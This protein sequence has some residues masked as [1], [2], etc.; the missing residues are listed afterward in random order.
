MQTHQ[1][2]KESLYKSAQNDYSK[3]SAELVELKTEVIRAIRGESKFAPEL[4]NGLIA[5][6]ENKL[7]EAESICNITKCELNS[8]KHR[9][10]EMQVKYDEVI[11]WTEL[12]DAADLAAKKMIVTNMI[13]RIEVGEGFKLHIDFSID[14]SHFNLNSRKCITRRP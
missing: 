7:A 11:S 8:C 4:L 6:A 14:L 5:E 12:Y 1:T 13:N 2:E 3:S 9:I 10:T